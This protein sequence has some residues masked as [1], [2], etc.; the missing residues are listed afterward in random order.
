L[1]T[2]SPPRPPPPAEPAADGLVHLLAVDRLPAGLKR[3]QGRLH[4]LAH[5]LRGRGA[6]LGDPLVG[7]PRPFRAR[8]PR[9]ACSNC[10]AESS[11]CFTRPCT[12]RTASASSSG[13]R[14]S[15]SRFLSAA[16]VMR[17]ALTRG[18]SCAFMAAVRSCPILSSS[19]MA[20]KDIRARAAS[21]YPRGVTRRAALL[22]LLLPVTLGAPVLHAEVTLARLADDAAAALLKTARGVPTQLRG[23]EDPRGRGS[24]LSLDLHAL[25]EARLPL[26]ARAS[27]GERRVRVT[28]GLPDDPGPP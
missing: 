26:A 1:A 11:R 2:P 16:L 14:F 6:G 18:A 8:P 4:D 25:I 9:P 7:P 24:G 17:S 27:G 3:G 10:V 28:S 20:D 5:V 13:A 22:C 19:D 15:I 23:R 21:R 12:T